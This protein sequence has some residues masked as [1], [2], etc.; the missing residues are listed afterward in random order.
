MVTVATHLA[1][2][3][4]A[5]GHCHVFLVTGG[6]A[7]FLNDALCHQ[8]GITPV[9]FRPEQAAEACARIANRPPILNVTTGPGGINALNGVFGAWTDSVPMIVLFGQVKSVQPASPKR[10]S[11]HLHGQR[12]LPKTALEPRDDI[13]ALVQDGQ[14]HR[15]ASGRCRQK[16]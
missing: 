3:L 15:R 12:K 5:S 14:Y 13:H 9:C 4:A 2:R 8:T 16:T 1:Q 10:A 6:G 7:M 11:T